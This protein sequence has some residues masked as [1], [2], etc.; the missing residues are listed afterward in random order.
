M[1]PAGRV[2][3]GRVVDDGENP[4]VGATIEAAS[5]SSDSR[6]LFEWRATTDADGRFVWE[7]APE[8]QEYAVYASGYETRSRL[9]LV[10]DGSEQTIRLTKGT[11]HAATRIFGHVVDAETRQPP[12]SVRVQIWETR[13]EPGRSSST[14]T[15]V[16]EDAGADGT[17]RLKT[18]PGTVSYVLEVQADGY[19]P[20]RRHQPGH[21][22]GRSEPP[23]SIGQGAPRRRHRSYS[24]GRVC[25]WRDAC[26]VRTS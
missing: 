8:V 23:H 24:I 11:G 26:L 1:M 19:W 15:T 20:E 12:P 14:V 6:T 9:P 3:R 5:P 4:V 21:Y 25:R 16:P 13:N 10:A 18:S 2:L 22:R 17:F 7:A